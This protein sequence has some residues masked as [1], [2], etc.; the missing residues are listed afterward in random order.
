M[1]REYELWVLVYANDN[2][3]NPELMGLLGRLTANEYKY[4]PDVINVAKDVQSN[5]TGSIPG[6]LDNASAEFLKAGYFPKENTSWEYM[7]DFGGMF[8]RMGTRTEP[9]PDLF[10]EHEGYTY[11]LVQGD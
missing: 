5:Y 4:S 8:R 10:I 11:Q 6:L 1:T 3:D 2:E 7:P 9:G